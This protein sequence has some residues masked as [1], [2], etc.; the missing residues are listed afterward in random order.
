[1]ILM[2]AYL[3]LDLITIVTYLQTGRQVMILM[4]AYLEGEGWSGPY[5]FVVFGGSRLVFT[6]KEPYLE[7]VG[8]PGGSRLALILKIPYL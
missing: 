5:S 8:V 2:A 4:V 3:E 1:M 7:Y 6:I